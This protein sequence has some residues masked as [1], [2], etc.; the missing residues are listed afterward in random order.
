MQVGFGN[1]TSHLHLV[2]RIGMC[3][4]LR[5]FPLMSSGMTLNY[6]HGQIN[7]TADC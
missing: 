5:A 4:A 2:L 3:G 7:V 6:T 1:R